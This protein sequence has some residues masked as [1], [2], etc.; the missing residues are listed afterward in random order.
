MTSET[1]N[2]T[3]LPAQTPPAWSVIHFTFSDRDTDSR[4]VVMCNNKCF[5]VHLSADNFSNSPK[6]TERY[7]FFLKV[8]DEFELDGVTVEDFWAS[9]PHFPEIAQYRPGNTADLGRLFQPRNF[10]LYLPNGLR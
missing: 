2:D 6:L 8:A 7:L 9:T 1:S 4:L 10:R 5:V 3:L